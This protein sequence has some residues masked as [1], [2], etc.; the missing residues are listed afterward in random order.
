MKN[1]PPP[2]TGRVTDRLAKYREVKARLSARSRG[3]PEIYNRYLYALRD[4]RIILTAS[5]NSAAIRARVT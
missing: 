5:R 2:S 3:P 4:F 1:P